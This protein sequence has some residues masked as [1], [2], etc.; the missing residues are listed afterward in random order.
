MLQAACERAA[1]VSWAAQSAARAASEHVVV[2][3][4]VVPLAGKA[5]SNP[6]PGPAVMTVISSPVTCKEMSWPLTLSTNDAQAPHEPSE[7][8]M[9]LVS[10]S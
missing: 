3:Q 10:T 6:A 5:G 1:L 2:V 9:P 4:T 8:A 7:L